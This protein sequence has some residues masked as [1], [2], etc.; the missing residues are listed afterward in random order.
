MQELW[1][2]VV[3]CECYA[4]VSNLGQVRTLPRIVQ[5]KDGRLQSVKGKI[6]KQTPISKKLGD[7]VGVGWSVNSNSYG[8]LVHRIVA[9]AWIPNPNDLPQVNHKDGN[10]QRCEVSNLEWITS[11]DNQKHA[12]ATG[13]RQPASDAI[14][15]SSKIQSQSKSI[16]CISNTTVYRSV[17][18]AGTLLNL[19][20]SY[21]VKSANLHQPVTYKGA[22]YQFEWIRGVN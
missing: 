7:Y 13:L 12:Y 19:P 14:A 10:K 1:K 6:L 17:R 8:G 18:S 22:Q 16:R 5:R 9:E 21:I 15:N 20:S 11:S 4:E 3:G 2:P